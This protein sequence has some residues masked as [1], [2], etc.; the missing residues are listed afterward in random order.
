MREYIRKDDKDS[1]IP[2]TDTPK[3]TTA[4]VTFNSDKTFNI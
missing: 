3:P 1:N 2:K 4:K